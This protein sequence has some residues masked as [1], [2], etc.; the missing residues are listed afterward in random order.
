MKTQKFKGSLGAGRHQYSVPETL[1]AQEE[2]AGA[3][4]W[5]ASTGSTTRR[6]GDARFE[7]QMRWMV[8]STRRG[9]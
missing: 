3:V 8:G 9:G 4:P 7:Y 2:A 1:E 5:S 6:L